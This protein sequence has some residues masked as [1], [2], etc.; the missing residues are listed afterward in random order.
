MNSDAFDLPTKKGLIDRL[1]PSMPLLVFT[2][3]M[4]L[5]DIFVTQAQRDAGKMPSVWVVMAREPADLHTLASGTSAPFRWEP[6][7]GQPQSRLW[8]DDYSNLLGAIKF[9][10]ND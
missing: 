1:T 10:A 9:F 3:S 6:L 7:H 2:V 8:T 4:F 5:N